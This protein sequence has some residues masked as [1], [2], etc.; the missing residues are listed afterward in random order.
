LFLAALDGQHVVLQGKVQ[1]VLRDAGHFEMHRV[2]IGV[3]F[4]VDRRREHAFAQPSSRPN[5]SV[6]N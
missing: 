3:F 6:S 2:S 5:K 1:I 4:D